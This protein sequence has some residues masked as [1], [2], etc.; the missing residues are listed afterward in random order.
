MRGRGIEREIDRACLRALAYDPEV[1]DPRGEWLYEIARIGG[2]VE[3]LPCTQCRK[4]ALAELARVPGRI[5]RDA[6]YDASP[7]TRKLA[8]RVAACARA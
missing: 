7:T 1:D 6:R 4:R 2:R 5:L 3:A 8:G